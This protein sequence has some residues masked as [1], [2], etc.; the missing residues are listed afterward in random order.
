ML[1]GGAAASLVPACPA[2]NLLAGKLP[3]Q[4]QE[5]QRNLSLLTDETLATEG[6]VWDASLAAIFETGASVVT[7]DFGQVVSV[8]HRS[9]SRPTRTTPTTSGDLSTARNTN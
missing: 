9:P 2:G 1:S 8:R 6:S 3:V 4:W 7:W 5:I